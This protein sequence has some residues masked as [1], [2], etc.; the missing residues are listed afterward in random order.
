[1]I[2]MKK[3]PIYIFSFVLAMLMI[4]GINA[5][6]LSVKEVLGKVTVFYTNAD[7]YQIDITYNMLRGLSGNNITE[8]Y[9][10][11]MVKK[12]SFTRMEALGSQVFQ[13]S[14]THLVVDHNQKVIA[15]NKSNAN[16]LSNS[17]LDVSDFL[18][19][20]DK[21]QIIDKGT[22]L[23]CEMV[24]T[25]K[26]F[27]LPY[28]KVVLYINKNNFSVAKQE[29][30][31]SNLIPFKNKENNTQEQDYGRL[32]ILLNHN[33]GGEVTTTELKDYVTIGSNNKPLLQKK[34]AA[35]KLIDQTKK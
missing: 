10:G 17:P 25:R 3:Q 35:Y 5:Q 1:M 21:S 15:Y 14:K 23:V 26:N 4:T 32:I 28:G 34:Y 19:Y 20:Y 24:S 7:Q 8:S 22:M 13:F 29:L 27:Q 12:G 2:K 16:G 6:K 9:K 33:M 31:F 11:S 18:K 30:Y